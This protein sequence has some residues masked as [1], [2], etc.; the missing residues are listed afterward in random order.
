[1]GF[2][3]RFPGGLKNALTFSFDDGRIYD[4]KL[5]EIFNRY[6]V[7]GTFHLNSG[8]FDSNDYVNTDEIADLYK[9]HEVACHSVTHPNPLC[10]TK[11]ALLNELVEDR[12]TLEKITSYPVRGFSYPYGIFYD[13]LIEVA[14]SVGLEYSR[15]VN[16]DPWFNLPNDF[17]KWNPS[18]HQSEA[19]ELSDKFLDFEGHRHPALFYIWGH[20]YEFNDNDNWDYIEAVVKKISGKKEVWYATN[21]EIKDYITAF[22]GLKSTLDETVIYNP[23]GIDVWFSADEKIIKI[24]PGETIKLN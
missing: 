20:S 3:L 11:T 5:V 13:E 12:R 4:R 14:K 18:C 19:M 8:T 22:R 16:S 17:M 15:T 9:G 23:S 6:G 10:I 1:M 2:E 7:K 24:G 21:I